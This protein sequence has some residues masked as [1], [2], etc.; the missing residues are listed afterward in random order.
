LPARFGLPSSRLSEEQFLQR[1][2]PD[3]LPR[4]RASMES[5]RRGN[6]LR[7]E[8]E[9]RFADALGDYHWLLSRGRVL[10]RDPESGYTLL[11]AG[12]YVDIDALKR[13]EAEL[14]QA[15]AQ[16]QAA[17]EAKTHLI[18]GISHELRTPLNAILGF[19]QLMRSE[20]RRVA[21]ECRYRWSP[22]H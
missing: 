15:T 16:A 17:S 6:A 2:H 5:M 7:Y 18:S 9:F 13:V 19:A 3:D 21:K 22:Y 10:E 12:T 11:L 1:L 4:V 8:N 14:R 20:E